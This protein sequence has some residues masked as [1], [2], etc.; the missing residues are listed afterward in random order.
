MNK[1]KNEI[2]NDED[3]LYLD[4]QP[5][6]KGEVFQK[7]SGSKEKGKPG[8]SKVICHYYKEG[9]F[10]KDGNNRKQNREKKGR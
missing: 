3:N 5:K 6:N 10:K 9:H 2:E 8:K 7:G 4:T 1:D